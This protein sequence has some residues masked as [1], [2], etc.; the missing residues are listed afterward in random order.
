M[1]AGSSD[2]RRHRLLRGDRARHVL[3][4][5]R[6]VG[7]A[8]AVEERDS[9][10][11][12]LLDDVDL[13]GRQIVAQLILADVGRPQLAG[14]GMPHHA[15]GVAQPRR[16]GAA[17]L[18]VGVEHLNRRA[19][20]VGLD[21]DVARR[22]DR[23]IEP[24]VTA[25]HQRPR[26][27]QRRRRRR[28]VGQLLRCAR[29]TAVDPAHPHQR[30]RRREVHVA[31]GERDTVRV[32]EAAQQDLGLGAAVTV[33]IGQRDD[34][35]TPADDQH[36]LGA[37]GEVAR[38]GEAR[39]EHADLEPGQQPPDRRAAPRLEAAVEAEAGRWPAWPPSRGFPR[40]R[41]FDDEP[42]PAA[43]MGNA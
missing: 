12:S 36:A 23:H 17:V 25:D 40:R 37:D 14:L 35:G 32:G 1:C 27:V 18:A 38:A 19:P 30:R 8:A 20:G 13:V 26:G 6:R 9:R 24:P 29:R 10:S 39:G 21:A 43:P 42:V 16:E 41:R 4:L 33:A 11:A 2:H 28:Q 5:G 3:H 15:D 22:A 7:H 34:L 31:V